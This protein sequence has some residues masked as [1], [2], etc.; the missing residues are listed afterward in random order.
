MDGWVVGNEF[1]AVSVCTLEP[2]SSDL[3][4]KCHLGLVHGCVSPN[5][6][7]D[8]YNS[9]FKDPPAL[10]FVVRVLFL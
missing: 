7:F 3:H 5:R 9:Q 10:F 1:Q 4:Q 2:S 8:S 6:D